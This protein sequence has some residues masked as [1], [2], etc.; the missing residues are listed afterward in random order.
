MQLVVKVKNEVM[1]CPQGLVFLVL[2]LCVGDCDGDYVMRKDM[3]LLGDRSDAC[4]SKK[5]VM[6]MALMMME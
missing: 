6:V 2:S 1:K 4:V 3:S 5:E